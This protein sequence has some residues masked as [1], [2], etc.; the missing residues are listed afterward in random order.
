MSRS[1]VL[2]ICLKLKDG[3]SEFIHA[4]K[5]CITPIKKKGVDNVY[6]GFSL[7]DLSKCHYY[8]WKWVI[9]KLRYFRFKLILFQ[10]SKLRLIP[11]VCHPLTIRV[12]KFGE[13][14]QMICRRRISGLLLCMHFQHRQQ[15][16]QHHQHQS[17]IKRSFSSCHAWI[18]GFR[19]SHC[20]DF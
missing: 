16:R 17:A 7:F 2:S 6:V 19:L 11:F 8:I 13:R 12:F 15:K 18:C 5:P 10:Y 1:R 4:D 9:I 14:V 3:C 20:T